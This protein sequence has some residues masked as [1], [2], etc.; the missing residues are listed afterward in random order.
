MK[1]RGD[2]PN[3]VAIRR[4]WARA[5]ARPWN[6]TR[7]DAHL[8]LIRGSSS[9]LTE[10]AE[11]VLGFGASA[12][13]SPPLLAGPQQVWRAAGFSPYTSLQLL[14]KSLTGEERVDGT[15][16]DLGDGAWARVVGIDAAAFGDAWKAELPA[17]VEA[18]RS[19]PASA[20]LGI[21]TDEEGEPAGYAIVAASSETGYLQRIAVHPD[22]HRRGF[23]RALTRAC[24][25]W[26]RRRGARVMILNTKPDNTP[27][28]SLYQAEGYTLLPD[29]LELLRYPD[30]SVTGP[31]G[32]GPP[33]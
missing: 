8:R 14:R 5:V 10:A 17:L 11:T 4:G 15:V 12:V 13:I 19:A 30:R 3:P 18:L 2:W 25:N 31:A 24:H 28:L 33:T 32:G 16:R 22:A 21:G 6:R 1:V 23:G 29:R 7:T 27:A 26:A 20:L 9:F